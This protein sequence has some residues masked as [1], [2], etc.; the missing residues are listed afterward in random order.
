MVGY[1]S[2]AKNRT[3]RKRNVYLNENGAASATPILVGYSV[4]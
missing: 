4:G 1:V 2:N 3:E